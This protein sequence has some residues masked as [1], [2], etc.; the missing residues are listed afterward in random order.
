MDIESRLALVRG[1][2]EE[3]ITDP[4]L[5]TL[6]EQNA[7][8]TAYDGFEPSG[9]A[10]L[11]FGLYRPLLLNDLLKAGVRFTLLLA[12]WHGWINNKMGGDLDAIRRVGDYFLEV[13]SAAGVDLDKVKA[14]WASDLVDSSDYWKRVVTVAKHTTVQRATRC[15]SIMG[16]KEGELLESAQYFYPAMQVADIFELG[17]DI[18][19][20]GLDQR[21]ANILSREIA[22]KLKWKKPVLV[23]HHMLAGLQGQVELDQAQTYDEQR[24]RDVKIASKMSKSKPASAIFVHD[25]PEQIRKKLHEAFCETK[26]VGNNP[27]LDYCKEIIFRAQKEFKIE[28]DRKF[29]GDLFFYSYE[30]L[31]EAFLKG[32]HPLDLKNATAAALDH[33]IAPVRTHFEKNK[34]AKDLLQF[35]RGQDVTR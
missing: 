26:N 16:R 18:C 15:L 20:L 35:V 9:L 13:W 28:R 34:K 22:D 2:A 5:R 6:L 24:D 3:I 17:V 31:E 30:D 21:R 12:D 19:Q 8:P 1:V 7:H 11:P 4:E 25:S 33:L 32:L 14:V 23:H 27:V 29:G 10:H